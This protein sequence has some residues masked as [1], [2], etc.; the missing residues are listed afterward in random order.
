MLAAAT[1]ALV[2]AANMSQGAYFSQSWG[3]VALAFLVPTAIV[4]VLGLV[5]APGRWRAAFALLVGAFASWTTASA[6]W[7]VSSS[8]TLRETERML[9]YVALA[10]GVALLARRGDA[11]AIVGGVLAGVVVVSGYALGSR[12]LPGLYSPYDVA[13]EG[14]KLALPI[15]YKNAL[16]LLTTLGAILAVGVAA[17][18]RSI[19]LRAVGGAVVPGLVV[20]LY[21]TFSRGAWAALAFGLVSMISVDSRR[22]RLLVTAVVVAPIAVVAVAIASRYEALTLKG[23]P[24]PADVEEQGLR[25]L[26]VLALLSALSAA[27]VLAV[28]LGERRRRPSPVMRRAV[29]LA[30]ALSVFAALVLGLMA[31]GGPRAAAAELVER[32]EAPYVPSGKDANTRYFSLS[33]RDRSE[34]FRFTWSLARERPIAGHGAGAF[35]YVWYERRPSENVIRDAHSLYLETLAELGGVGL[36]LLGLAL[37]TP[38]AAAVTSRRARLVPAG[39]GAYL[40]WATH[41]ALDWDWEMV[42][43]TVAGLLVGSAALLAAERGPRRR[44]GERARVLLIGTFVLLSLAAVVSLVGNQALFAGR[45]AAA[46]GDWRVALEHARRA[47]ALLVWSHEPAIVR[48]DAL[49]GLG[50]RE[51]ALEAYRAAVASD[52]RNWVAWLRLAQAARGAE[53][54]RAYAR[55]RM[56]NPLEEELPG[57]SGERG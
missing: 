23:D 46:R 8:G 34:T 28:S 16:G 29:E 11:S 55:V 5:E 42:G 20:T 32:F 4:L 14:W 49:A 3:W 45:D 30:L 38:L 56:L 54:A 53:R 36:G 25:L 37:V 17:H 35:E 47:D 2:A 41:A 7:S 9:V 18:A 27:G 40:A 57:A 12:L 52:E 19:A 44:L 31:V 1:G 13:T 50:D 39:V 22:F 21:L 43:V 51:G 26:L 48:G 10:L 15:G 24:P 6:L 33:G